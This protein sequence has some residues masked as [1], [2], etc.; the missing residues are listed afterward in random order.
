VDLI[1]GAGSSLVQQVL[2]VV[3]H[4]SVHVP[5]FLLSCT[6]LSLLTLQYL[7]RF[8][9]LVQQGTYSKASLHSPKCGGKS[10]A[11]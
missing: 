3:K 7:I 1:S 11:C 10:G 4:S 8:K 2:S 6:V 9:M 5:I